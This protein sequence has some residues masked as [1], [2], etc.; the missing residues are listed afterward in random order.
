MSEI[1]NS[2]T[3]LGEP[4]IRLW[5]QFSEFPTREEVSESI[6][7]FKPRSLANLDIKGRGPTGRKVFGGRFVIP[8]NRWWS[9]LP[10][11]PG[12]PSLVNLFLKSRNRWA[13][14]QSRQKGNSHVFH[15]KTYSKRS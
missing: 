10:L 4:Y 1:P 2:I 9:G 8:A 13:P 5:E 6:R 12:R 11:W 7:V 15:H 14:P 3:A